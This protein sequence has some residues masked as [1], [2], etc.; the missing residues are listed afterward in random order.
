MQGYIE[1]FLNHHPE[2]RIKYQVSGSL[3]AVDYFI[4][5]S[6]SYLFKIPNPKSPIQNVEICV[7]CFYFYFRWML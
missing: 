2:S 1:K 5:S 6:V 4:L 7:L 3:W